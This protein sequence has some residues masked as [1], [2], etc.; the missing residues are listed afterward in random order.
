M[1]LALNEYANDT[2]KIFVRGSDHLRDT[3]RPRSPATVNRMRAMLGTIFRHARLEW[4]AAGLTPWKP[5]LGPEG[6]RTS[7]RHAPLVG[8]RWSSPSA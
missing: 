5:G 2:V 4:G 1:W 6:S 8:R 7:R 3:G